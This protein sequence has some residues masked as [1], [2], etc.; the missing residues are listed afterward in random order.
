MEQNSACDDS[1]RIAH[2]PFESMSPRTPRQTWMAEILRPR[3]LGE[4]FSQTF[5][6]VFGNLLALIAIQIIFCLPVA[7]LN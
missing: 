4:L 1:A 3:S 2:D 7:V 5:N 6:L